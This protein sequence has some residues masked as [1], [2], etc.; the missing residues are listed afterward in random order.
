M[1]KRLFGHLPIHK[2]GVTKKL[3]YEFHELGMDE[4]LMNIYEVVN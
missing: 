4:W 2:V 3:A 1:I